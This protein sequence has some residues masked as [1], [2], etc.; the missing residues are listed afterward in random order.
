MRRRALA[1]YNDVM[2][3]IGASTKED[4]VLN[5]DETQRTYKGDLN[6]RIIDATQQVPNGDARVNEPWLQG[7]NLNHEPVRRVFDIYYG[8]SFVSSVN[9]VAVGGFRAYLPYPR[10]ADR[11]VITHW[12][13]K[14]AQIVQP[15]TDELDS[16]L[17][18]THIQVRS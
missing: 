13:Y 14:F 15:A 6:I 17:Q 18:R 11:L 10:S 3:K 5:H 7:L 16:Y 2:A 1:T 12:Q 4:W 8:N 9:M